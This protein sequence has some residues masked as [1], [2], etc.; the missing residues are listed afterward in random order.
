[1]PT[2]LRQDGFKIQIFVDDH[3]PPHVYARYD[4]A[5]VVV[6]LAEAAGQVPTIRTVKH[7]SAEI[8]RSALQLVAEHNDY[9]LEQWR[10]IH[11]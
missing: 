10:L 2:I 1:M 11:G 6:N 9:L 8:Q 3:E 4:R 5:L 7:A